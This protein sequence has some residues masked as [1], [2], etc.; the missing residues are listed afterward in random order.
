MKCKYIIGGLLLLCAG[1]YPLVLTS[2]PPEGGEQ[3][4]SAQVR[5]R[6]LAA[7]RVLSY[8]SQVYQRRDGLAVAHYG[9]PLDMYMLTDRAGHV[10]LFT[11]VDSL[12]QQV[13]D[14]AFGSRNSILYCLLHNRFGDMA[15]RDLG[16]RTDSS[17]VL[18]GHQ[19]TRWKPADGGKRAVGHVIL[20]HTEGKII[21]A[22][23]YG[24]KGALMRKTYYGAHQTLR[25]RRMP[26][27]I[28]DISYLNPA[29]TDSIIEKMTYEEIRFD[30]EADTTLAQFKIPAYART[31]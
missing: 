19:L 24:N 7:G 20:A 15:L 16:W 5:V 25:Q 12:V 17:W 30:A 29:A 4:V 21:Y 11:P 31:R 2:S 14:P 1:F 8:T 18:A 23:Y 28:T 10:Q 27:S 13:D 22:A 6:K 3:Q 9:P 26:M